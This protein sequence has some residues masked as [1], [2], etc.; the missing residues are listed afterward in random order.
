MHG[1][2]Y[3]V[4]KH[5]TVTFKDNNTPISTQFDDVYFCKENGLAETKH[6]FLDS[7]NLPQAWA[8]YTH[9]HVCETGFGTGLNFLATAKLFEETAR[10]DQKLFYTSIE[11]HPLKK[12]DI[13]KSLSHWKA[14]FGDLYDLYLEH[15][16]IAIDG[17]HPI[18][19]KPN[20][21]LVLIFD[22]VDKAITELNDAQDFFFLDGFA[23]A[24]NPDMWSDVLFKNMARLSHHKTTFS[25]FTAASFVKHAL[26]ENDFDVKKVKGYRY[27]R[28]MLIGQF[29]GKKTRPE[30]HNKKQVITICGAG[31]A[32]SCL[33]WFLKKIQQDIV[34]VDKDTS[35]NNAS[36]N[37]WGLINPR[38]GAVRIPA[39]DYLNASFALFLRHAPKH[40][41]Q[42]IGAHHF[43]ENAEKKLRHH[44]FLTHI[45]WPDELAQETKEGLFFPDAGICSPKELRDFYLKDIDV[46]YGTDGDILAT[47]YDTT[48]GNLPLQKIRGQISYA[49]APNH[50]VQNIYFY[51]HYHA[52]TSGDTLVFG[53]TF[54]DWADHEGVTDK[55]HQR[56]L[57]ALD[58][59]GDV[60]ITHGWSGFRCSSKD[61]L[62][63][64]GKLED[65]YLSIAH[66]SHGMISSLTASYIIAYELGL[67]PQ[68]F[69]AKMLESVSP[70]RYNKT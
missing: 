65:K 36:A 68:P 53:A 26:E 25:T 48:I 20:I 28:A 49:D 29:K 55:D 45:S 59:K 15:Y 24:K 33:A 9:I 30:S 5:S 31:L 13:E 34:L 54:D 46:T 12:E 64:I 35:L 60:T 62:P 7:N 22:D 50:N 21:F 17:F 70:T 18:M 47:S 66:G 11:K 63:I 3:A 51:G 39:F 57:D 61:R 27:K 41:F 43:A 67:I 40:L 6:V 44:K 10:K 69:S 52:P 19:I 8:D 37:Q 56:N 2:K 23:P 38:V 14:H 32:G 58:Y 42:K 1:T 4:P 16:P